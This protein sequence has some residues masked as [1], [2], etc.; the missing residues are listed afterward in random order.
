M[1]EL[2]KVLL[3]DDG[4]FLVLLLRNAKWYMA[5]VATTNR[6]IDLATIIDVKKTKK[7]ACV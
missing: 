4:A 6:M 5:K 2:G 1:M 3:Q 7:E